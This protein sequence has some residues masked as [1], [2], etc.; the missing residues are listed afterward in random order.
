MVR[1]PKSPKTGR[2]SPQRTTKESAN[3][4]E[5]IGQ[6]G[7]SASHEKPNGRKRRGSGNVG[8]SIVRRPLIEEEP[9]Q[10]A[11]LIDFN[12]TNTNIV[13]Q[14]RMIATY[15]FAMDEEMRAKMVEAVK[16]CLKSGNPELML[17]ATSAGARLMA[18]NLG[19]FKQL[20]SDQVQRHLSF[21]KKQT[22]EQEKKQRVLDSMSDDELELLEKMADRLGGVIDV[23][24]T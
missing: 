12:T 7:R 21:D 22:L 6:S 13:Q 17:A 23:E 18:I 3:G 2:G 24:G 10:R 8:K 14:L 20:A 15:P 4:L 9:V 19:T 1:K 16:L 5:W 11:E